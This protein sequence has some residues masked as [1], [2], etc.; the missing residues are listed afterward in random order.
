MTFWVVVWCCIIHILYGDSMVRVT[1]NNGS[2]DGCGLVVSCADGLV[3]TTTNCAISWLMGG[4]AQVVTDKG[5]TDAHIIASDPLYGLCML[6]VD[7]AKVL[8]A[9]QECVWARTVQSCGHARF[10]QN[11][12]ARN[13]IASCAQRAEMIYCAHPAQNVLLHAGVGNDQKEAVFV[14]DRQE[15]MALWMGLGWVPMQPLQRFVQEA[16]KQLKVNKKTLGEGYAFRRIMA[17]PMDVPVLDDMCG[18]QGWTG[19]ELVVVMVDQDGGSGMQTGDVIVSVEGVPLHGSMDVL[20][21][22]VNQLKKNMV[23]CG[24]L[25]DRKRLSLS[26]PVM[27]IVEEKPESFS[28]KDWTFWRVSKR[29]SMAYGVPVGS[30]LQDGR[31]VERVYGRAVSYADLQAMLKDEQ[32]K[33]NRGFLTIQYG[34]LDRPAVS[35][36]HHNMGRDVRLIGS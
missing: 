18:H 24:I 3:L 5:A 36:T 28:F 13:K 21:R 15:V 19:R 26:V 7:N 2:C 4:K 10:F 12:Y 31:V 8:Q 32:M 35:F 29:M 14:N 11:G 16:K 33:K 17:C 30:A 25:R 27:H 20:I 23:V 6:Q 1:R 22:T 34:E 9:S